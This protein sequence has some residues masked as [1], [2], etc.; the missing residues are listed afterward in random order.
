MEVTFVNNIEMRVQAQIYN[1]RTLVYTYVADPGETC[2]L[3]AS[4]VRFDIFFKNSVTGWEIAR[5]LGSS[6]TTLTLSQKKG[7]YNLT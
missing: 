5:Q 1:G 3:P 4:S 7:R 2:V 6:A